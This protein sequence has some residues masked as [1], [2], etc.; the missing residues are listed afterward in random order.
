MGDYDS[1]YDNV[2]AAVPIELGTI[3]EPVPGVEPLLPDGYNPDAVMHYPD[4]FHVPRIGDNPAMVY[5][6]GLGS[7]DSRRA[8]RDRLEYVAALL[9]VDDKA[10]HWYGGGLRLTALPWAKLRYQ[11]VAALRARM[12][13]SGQAPATIN[14][15]L[16]A[17]RGVAREAYNLGQISADDY[18]RIRNV[19]NVRGSRLPT[20][21]AITRGEL[22]ALLDA[23]AAD[24][25]AAGRRDA[26]VIALAYAGGLRRSE[27]VKLDLD[28][29]TPE[30]GELRVRGGKGNKQ[31][32][33]WADN[34]AADALAEWI[35]VRG[36]EPGPLFVPVSQTG[37]PIMRRMTSQVI[38]NLLNKRAGEAGVRELSPHDMRRTFI[39]DLLDAGADLATVSTLAGHASPTTTA[40]YDRRPDAVRRKAIGLLHVPFK[41]RAKTVS[42]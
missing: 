31:R 17:L 26:A 5:L 25:S 19:K 12:L 30:T 21:R 24:D 35:D 34:G 9:G 2:R 39:G 7:P 20:G 15:A 32:L 16:S 3:A 40:R 29:Y 27:L 4:A 38:R 33:L 28:D 37:E 1:D 18:Q 8:M 22:V 36:A 14:L 42:K 13:A 41:S 23:C 6:G 10:A 11:H